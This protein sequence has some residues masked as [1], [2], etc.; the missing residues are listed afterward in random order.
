MSKRYNNL[1]NQ[2]EDEEDSK[3]K[4][5]IEMQLYKKYGTRKKCVRCGS[6]LLISNLKGYKYLCLKCNENMYEFESR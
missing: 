2:F 6:Q 4:S 3:K 1:L 5:R